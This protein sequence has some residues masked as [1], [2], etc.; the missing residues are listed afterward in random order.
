MRNVN[1][2]EELISG[3]LGDGEKVLWAGRPT[4]MKLLEMPY[5][6]AI[7]IRWIICLVCVIFALWYGYVFVPA[8]EGLNVNANVIVLVVI[9]IALVVSLLPLLDI[10]KLKSKSFYYITNKRAITLVTGS[11]GKHKEKLF[12]DISEI[13]Y[14]SIAENRGD[15]F[16]GEKLKNSSKKARVYVLTPPNDEDNVKPLVFH[17]VVN[18][19]EIV[20]LFPPLA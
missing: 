18:P 8:S 17:S 16:I 6:A 20:G 12:S 2:L 4:G 19:E 14:E 15:I 10:I 11:A 5:G 3:E 7:I 13:T 1:A 9:V